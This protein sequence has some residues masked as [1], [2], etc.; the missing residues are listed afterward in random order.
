MKDS[1]TARRR[2][3]Y[4]SPNE[5]DPRGLPASGVLQLDG[6][7]EAY[8]YE[9]CAGTSCLNFMRSGINSHGRYCHEVPI[10]TERD[11]T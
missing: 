10:S 5:A 1:P 8:R 2:G 11:Q 6:E 4:A 3:R 9:F 7:E